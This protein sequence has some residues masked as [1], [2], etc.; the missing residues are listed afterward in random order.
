MKNAKKSAVI[1]LMA[2]SFF[3]RVPAV[4]AAIPVPTIGAEL[5]VQLQQAKE[6]L[7]E[8]KKM[9]EQIQSKI[10]TIKN[11][12]PK[13][14]LAA[15]KGYLE[16]EAK[17]MM[18]DAIAKI[19]LP[20]ELKEAGL[21]DEMLKN[22][23]KLKDWAEGMAKKGISEKGIDSDARAACFKARDAL[24]KKMAKESMADALT[25]NQDIATGQDVKDVQEVS[26]NAE[27][28]QQQ[29]QAKNI[30]LGKRLKQEA[31]NLKLQ[32]NSLLNSSIGSMCD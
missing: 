2:V 5:K 6:H 11:I 7:D 29:E 18:K 14:A 22:P 1:G 17:K 31:R 23:D 32:A 25:A 9:K 26:K 21:T 8:L 3:F 20:K 16:S 13:E 30:A 24:K 19:E 15:G 12:G 27:N 4:N 28:Q 10:E